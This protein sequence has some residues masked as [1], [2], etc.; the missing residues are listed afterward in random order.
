ME[1]GDVVTWGDPGLGGDSSR[2]QGK[3]RNVQPL[4]VRLLP[5][6]NLGLF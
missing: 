5:F 4:L 3:L 2:V 6:W 1:S